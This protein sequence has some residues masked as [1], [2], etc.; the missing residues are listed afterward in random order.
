MR[1]TAW[2]PTTVVAFREVE[3]ADP[4]GTSCKA[5]PTRAPARAAALSNS[6]NTTPADQPGVQV[7]NRCLIQ[8]GLLQ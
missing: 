8:S 7:V 2:S 3:Q 1:Q 6:G 5:C 4:T